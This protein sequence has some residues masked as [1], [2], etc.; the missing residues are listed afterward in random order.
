MK[1]LRILVAVINTRNG[2]KCAKYLLINCSGESFFICQAKVKIK[3]HPAAK[4]SVNG[5]IQSCSAV[6]KVLC[7][8]TM[9]RMRKPLTAS[10]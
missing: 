9:H 7:S 10:K 6:S 5:R 3:K 4:A 8:K 1:K 2:Q